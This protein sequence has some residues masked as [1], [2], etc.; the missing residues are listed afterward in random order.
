MENVFRRRMT[1]IALPVN[2]LLVTM[3]D[4]VNRHIVLITV[5]VHKTDFAILKQENAH[6]ISNYFLS[7]LVIFKGRLSKF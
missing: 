2:A 6:V 3:V 7:N 4:I 1:L 5:V